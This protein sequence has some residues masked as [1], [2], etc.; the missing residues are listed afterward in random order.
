MK[1]AGGVRFG[2]IGNAVHL[3]A[4]RPGAP[5]NAVHGPVAETRG[6]RPTAGTSAGPIH[7]DPCGTSTGVYGAYPPP[8]PPGASTL[9]IGKTTVRQVLVLSHNA[10][11]A[12]TPVSHWQDKSIPL[13]NIRGE[14]AATN[15]PNAAEP[16]P[17]A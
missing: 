4:V 13:F 9:K 11:M 16:R 6:Q 15:C 1:S 10:T 12:V 7:R 17:R 3:G 5:Q 2:E 8:P 14:A